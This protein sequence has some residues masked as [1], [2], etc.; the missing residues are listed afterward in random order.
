MGDVSH[1]SPIRAG[2]AIA[3]LCPTPDGRIREFSI[4]PTDFTNWVEIGP[5]LFH[6][7]PTSCMVV[8][9]NPSNLADACE[10]LSRW[11]ITP[12][13]ATTG[14]RQLRSLASAIWT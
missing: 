11:G 7:R 14:P 10:L 8:D 6:C 12:I 13:L 5:L 3:L 2:K 9:D 1:Q 4:V